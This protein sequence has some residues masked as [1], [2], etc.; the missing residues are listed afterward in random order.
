MTLIKQYS[1]PQISDETYCQR[2]DHKH[3]QLAWEVALRSVLQSLFTQ[4]RR[5]FLFVDGLNH[6][7]SL[8]HI[9]RMVELLQV[10]L[11]QDF[12]NVSIAIFSRPLDELE[13]LVELADVSVRVTQLEPDLSEYIHIKVSRK[14]KPMLAKANLDHDQDALAVIEK[15]MAEA[16]AGLY[17][18]QRAQ[19]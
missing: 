2:N 9:K 11:E 15:S 18:F 13:P 7:D 12:G 10:V 3:I 4:F 8:I 19:P 16:S 14:V 17:V 6:L 5:T 1:L